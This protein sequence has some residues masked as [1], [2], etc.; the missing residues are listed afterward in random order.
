MIRELDILCTKRKAT[1]QSC[2]GEIPADHVRTRVLYWDNNYYKSY[3]LH[4]FNVDWHKRLI[5]AAEKQCKR[6]KEELDGIEV[7][8]KDYAYQEVEVALLK[9]I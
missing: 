2:K 8:K 6:M 4:H 3:H 5:A 7:L 9:P 1:C